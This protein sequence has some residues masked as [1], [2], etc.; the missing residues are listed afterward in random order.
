MTNIHVIAYLLASYAPKNLMVWCQLICTRHPSELRQFVDSNKSIST[1]LDL[2]SQKSFSAA[3]CPSR[4]NNYLFAM[5]VK[6]LIPSVCPAPCGSKRRHISF[7]KKHKLVKRTVQS[8]TW[9]YQTPLQNLVRLTKT[10]NIS[11]Y[12]S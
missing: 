4:W 5:T 6:W 8:V 10:I 2:S 7:Y 9:F 12:F 11:Y 3:L 1:A